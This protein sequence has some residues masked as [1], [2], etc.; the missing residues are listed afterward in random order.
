MGYFPEGARPR[1]LVW[2]S[3][4]GALYA[5]HHVYNIGSSTNVLLQL[6]CWCPGCRGFQ[7]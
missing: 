3:D 1:N 6:F 7:G 4:T 5:A 2:N